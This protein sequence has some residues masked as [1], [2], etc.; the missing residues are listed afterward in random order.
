MHCFISTFVNFSDF[1]VI[2]FYFHAIAFEKYMWC[3]F[4]LLK[5]LKIC[6]VTKHVKTVQCALEEKVYSAAVG[7]NVLYLPVRSIWSKVLSKDSM[8]LLLISF[9]AVILHLI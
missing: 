5:F 4:N 3:D 8:S 9:D 6:C 1:L 2:N 7:Y